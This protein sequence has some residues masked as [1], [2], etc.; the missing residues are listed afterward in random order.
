MAP[1]L[2][3]GNL[4]EPLTFIRGKVLIQK[5]I[6]WVSFEEDSRNEKGSGYQGKLNDMECCTELIRCRGL[7]RS[8]GS[9]ETYSQG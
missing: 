2:R 8:A 7:W 1:L 5:D 3:L 6:E 4:A 9:L